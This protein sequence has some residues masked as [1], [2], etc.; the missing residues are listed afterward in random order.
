MSYNYDKELADLIPMLPEVKIDDLQMARDG[1]NE[2]MM[3]MNADVDVS[4]LDLH[5][6]YIP[7]PQAAP[8][9]KVRVYSPK[10]KQP[11]VPALLYIHGGGFVVGNIDTE[12]GLSATI[13]QKLGIV[14][15]S[16][17]YRLAPE[18]P[19]PAGLQD[20]YAALEWLYNNANTLGVDV[21]RIGV[22][23]Q[24]AGGGLAAAL[25][26]MTRDKG[27][28]ALCFQYLGIPELDDRL[29]TTSMREYDD[30]PMWNRPSAILSWKYYL[31]D[32]YVPGSAEVPVYA[33]PARAEDLRG[34]PPAYV[35]AME[36]DPLRDEAVLFALKLMGAGVPVELHTFPGTFHG[37]SLFPGAAVSIRQDKEM[38][39]VLGRGLEV[40]SD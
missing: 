33:A 13:S 29:E 15:V 36:F 16:V 39:E 38:L 27:G 25:A 21:G 30:T 14:I 12:H 11:N 23:G 2:M 17:E 20:C 5:E 7:G 37:S 40:K 1:I 34:L 35:S 28:P 9:V 3:E 32:K 8:E 4:A 19:F 24:S 6:K 31:G 10:Q 22:F 26:L 18:H